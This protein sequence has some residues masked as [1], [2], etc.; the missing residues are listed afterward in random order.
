MFVPFNLPTFQQFPVLFNAPSQPPDRSFQRIPRRGL[1]GA[2][3]DHVIECHRDVGAEL[4]L[5]FDGTLGRD[6][7]AAAI[8]VALEFDALLVDATK[9]CEREYLEAAGIGQQRPLP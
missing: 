2:S 7:P 9:A 3:G 4:R 6:H 5:D 1:V 8:H